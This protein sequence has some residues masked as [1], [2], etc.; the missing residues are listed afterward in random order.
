[1]EEGREDKSRIGDLKELLWQPQQKARVAAT[2]MERGRWAQNVFRD[3]TVCTSDRLDVGVNQG[4]M[5]RITVGVDVKHMDS[6][7]ESSAFKS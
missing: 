1:M 2:V 7:A 3:G 4:E 6:D 5:P